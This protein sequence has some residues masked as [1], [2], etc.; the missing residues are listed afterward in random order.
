MFEVTYSDQ[1]TNLLTSITV[2]SDK[3]G[4]KIEI[5]DINTKQSEVT[6]FTTSI[7]SHTV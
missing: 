3:Q 7:E 1:K 2:K 5:Q 6:Q 4:S